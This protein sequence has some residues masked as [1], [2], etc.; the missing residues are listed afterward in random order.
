MLKFDY[1]SQ[2]TYVEA[3]EK[4]NTILFILQPLLLSLFLSALII[5]R[6]LVVTYRKKLFDYPDERKVHQTAIPRLG[7]FSFL[8]S[9]LFAFL[10][11]I[12]VRYLTGY[13]IPA[14]SLGFV[15]PELFFLIC[16]L[17]LLYLAG[18]KDDLVGLRYRSKFVIQVLAVSM[19][20][21]SGL[22]I[23]NLYGL[24]G[25]HALSPWIGIPF[26]LL[27]VVFIVNAINLIDGLD[28]LAS[29]LASISLVIMGILFFMDG[30]SIYA[31]LAF[32][33]LGTLIP[34]FLYNVFGKAE[35]CKKIFM[36]DTGSLT[37]G[38]VLAFLV[39]RYSSCHP[40]LKP[41]SEDAFVIAFST[42]LVPIFDVFRVMLVR[43][44]NHKHIFTA[45]KN[46]IHHKLLSIGFVPRKA[47]LSILLLSVLFCGLN[48]IMIAYFNITVLLI[49]DIVIYTILNLW[50]DRIRDRK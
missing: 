32:A 14:G 21:L 12:G 39:V 10:F 31:I 19:L 34:F 8:P 43:A 44:R 36:G 41:C 2:R 37:L 33:T 15:V 29:G 17:I 4:M 22:W 23:N 24:L 50:L 27:A 42:L 18:L 45:D 20:P 3:L 9:I 16:G 38:Y 13:E 26:T 7:G 11:T 5:P 48:R 1:I 40:E 28:G 35:R 30:L 49:V 6:I 47:M 25:I 46:H